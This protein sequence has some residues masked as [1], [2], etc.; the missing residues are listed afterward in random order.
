MRMRSGWGE[1]LEDIPFELVGKVASACAV[2]EAGDVERG[3]AAARHVASGQESTR[4]SSANAWTSALAHSLGRQRSPTP[5]R[6]LRL[7]LVKETLILMVC[8]LPKGLFVWMLHSETYS[9]G[10]SVRPI[11][12]GPTK[13]AR[14]RIAI[15]PL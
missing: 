14:E 15:R 6:S 7:V 5:G 3:A 4:G 11:G 12:K 8:L 10:T 9:K 13:Q 2:A 1:A